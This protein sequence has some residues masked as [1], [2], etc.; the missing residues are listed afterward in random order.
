[1]LAGERFCHFIGLFYEIIYLFA[2]V[3]L[4]HFQLFPFYYEYHIIVAV[5]VNPVIT[6]LIIVLTIILI[7]DSFI[8]LLHH[9]YSIFFCHIVFS[10]LSNH[11]TLLLNIFLFSLSFILAPSLLSILSNNVINT[12]H[13]P[14]HTR[15]VTLLYI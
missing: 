4:V 8:F 9:N 1:M 14:I 15:M 3:V 10:C 2:V 6:M 7:F 5:P 12:P 13:C 11:V